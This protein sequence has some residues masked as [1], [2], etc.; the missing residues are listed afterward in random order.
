MTLYT[1]TK[2]WMGNG[3]KILMLKVQHSTK[4]VF[5]GLKG[6]VSFLAHCDEYR[7]QITT[8]YLKN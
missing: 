4:N 1:T 3:Q 5:E 8:N 7:W 2:A 6:F